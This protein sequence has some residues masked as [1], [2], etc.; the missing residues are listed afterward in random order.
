MA[1]PL[2]RLRGT[3]LRSAWCRFASEY[4]SHFLGFS[5]TKGKY[6]GVLYVFLNLVSNVWMNCIG[7][8]DPPCYSICLDGWYSMCPF[9][10]NMQRC[11]S[12]FAFSIFNCISY[13]IES[14]FTFLNAINPTGVQSVNLKCCS[15]LIYCEKM[16][17][18]CCIFQ[19]NSSLLHPEIKCLICISVCCL[20]VSAV[21]KSLWALLEVLL[22]A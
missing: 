15:Y 6:L 5:K 9:S 11:L 13:Y 21:D 7:T 3:S 22:L 19:V 12:R 14:R 16:C 4:L 17:P 1:E 18:F 8:F 20:T 2:L 10:T